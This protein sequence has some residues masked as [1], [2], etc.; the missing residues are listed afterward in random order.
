MNPEI[1]LQGF[2]LRYSPSADWALAGLTLSIPSGACCAILGPTS[3][4]KTTLL[5]TLSGLLGKHHPA[6]EARGALS[7][8]D[9]EQTTIPREMLFPAVG[10]VLQDPYVMISGIHETVEEEIAFTLQNLGIPQ[11]EIRSRVRE[12]LSM[13]HLEEFARRHPLRLSGG[14]L[15]RVALA[16]ILVAK[17]SVLLLDEPRNSLDSA[18]QDMLAR[19]LRALR[20]TTTVLFTDYDIDLAMAAADYVVVFDKGICT[21]HG[22]KQGFLENFEKFSSILLSD[23]WTRSL[24]LLANTQAGTSKISRIRKIFGLS[25]ANT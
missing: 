19:L 2:S 21:Y 22:D 24:P 6:A 1:S 8:K 16:S 18:G 7:F 23:S 9:R 14:E 25:N 4:G 11:A 17:P 12:T 15:Q 20:G 13:L 5:Q 3:S 10:M